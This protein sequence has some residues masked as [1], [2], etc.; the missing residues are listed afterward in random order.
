MGLYCCTTCFLKNYRFIDS[1]KKAHVELMHTA[2]SKRVET[3]SA[4]RISD[5]S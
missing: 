5:P 1:V 3:S 4:I 2:L